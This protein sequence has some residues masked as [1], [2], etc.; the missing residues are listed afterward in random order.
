MQRGKSTLFN[1]IKSISGTKFYKQDVS[2][3]EMK[4]WISKNWRK[5]INSLNDFAK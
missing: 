4:R 1:F 5:F 2:L 3:R